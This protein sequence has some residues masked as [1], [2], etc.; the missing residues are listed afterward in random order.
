MI[1]IVIPSLNEEK[2]LPDLLKQLNSDGLKKKYNFEIIL[3]DGGSKDS[4]VELALESCDK[5]IVHTNHFRQTIAQG[6]NAG[7]K[8]AEG[9][10]LIF[11]CADCR[12]DNPI[13]F[14]D[15]VRDEFISSHY[16]AATFKFDVFPEEK[17]WSDYIFHSIYN[18]YVKILNFVG[19]GMGRG[20]CQVIKRKYFEMFNGYNEN[21]TAGEDYDLYRKIK[22]VGRLKLA[23]NIKIFESA[24]RYRKFGYRKVILMWLR[25]A[26]NVMN[27]IRNQIPEWEEVR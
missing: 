15:F 20:E 16:S 6:K 10:I 1:S 23:F 27:L 26:L 8:A 13:Q 9:E 3:S 7:A 12:I 22:R 2:L 4:T 24:R 21:L 17:K 25:N 14:F 18:T 11:L 5:V 19:H